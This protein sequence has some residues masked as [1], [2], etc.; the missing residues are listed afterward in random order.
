MLTLNAQYLPKG[1]AYEVQTWYTDGPRRSTTNAVISKVKGQGRKVT[2]RVWQVFANKS[3][4]K[5]PRNTKIGGKVTY[6]TDNNVYKFQGQRP[7]VK[8]TWSIT[9]HNNTSFRTAIE[10]Y[11]HSLGG[12]TSTITLLPRFVVIRYSLG[13]DTDKSN[14]AWVRTLWVHSS[15]ENFYSVLYGI[16]AL[17]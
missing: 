11:S 14:T 4:T 17:V 1:K 2:W 13:G 3:R 5:R 16:V 9:L 8:V 7:K 6:L 15:W 12:D 10:F